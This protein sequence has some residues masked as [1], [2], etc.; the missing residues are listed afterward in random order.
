MTI[1]VVLVILDGVTADETRADHHDIG[2]ISKTLLGE[3]TSLVAILNGEKS[4]DFQKLQRTTSKTKPMQY[5]Y[6]VTK[7]AVGLQILKYSK[8]CLV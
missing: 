8:V 5:L 2:R 7:L 4:T 6:R 1:A 3:E